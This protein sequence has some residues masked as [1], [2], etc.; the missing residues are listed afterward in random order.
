[1]TGITP[2]QASSILKQLYPD[3]RIK[4]Q[5]YK[6]HP[7]LDMVPKMESFDGEAMKI[8]I[9]WGGHT[10]IAAAFATAQAVQAGGKYSHF[11][12]TRVNHY[13]VT[14]VQMEAYEAAMSKGKGAFIAL[15]ESETDGLLQNMG[16][17]LSRALFRNSGGAVGQ[18]GGVSTVTLTLKNKADVVNFEVGQVINSDDT[19][20]TAGGAADAEDITITAIDRDAGT[21]TA[22]VTWTAGGNFSNDDYLFHKGN[23]GVCLSGLASWIPST[24]PS[25]TLFFGCDRS[26]DVTRL[27]GVRYDGSSD[28]IEE[29]LQTTEL[30]LDREGGRPDVVLMHN[31]DYGALR[32]SLGSRV[33]YDRIKSSVGPMSF[34]S[35]VLQGINNV[36]IVVDRDCPKG[37]AYMLQMDTWKLCSLGAAPRFADNAG[38]GSHLILASEDAVE[39][40]A[41]YRAQLSCNA[42]GRNAVITL[43]SA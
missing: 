30:R 27:G 1:M 18:V 17:Q 32:N 36:R 8:P 14:T 19:D 28:S 29:A 33:V 42:P 31:E 40:R 13:G 16:N 12:L 15:L 41:L 24:A 43:P 23:F 21:L 39:W 22:G 9:H 20:G 37:K 25:A 26:V 11:L 3:D 7:F 34:T 5:G 6:G 35:I 4:F 38:L 2:T 10:G